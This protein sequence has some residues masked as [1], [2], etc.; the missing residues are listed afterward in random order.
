MNHNEIDSTQKILVNL[1][2]FNKSSIDFMVYTFTITTNW[3][4]YLRVKQDVLL[5]INEIIE[6][7]NA[8]IAFPT[9]TIHSEDSNHEDNDHIVQNMIS[10]N[11]KRL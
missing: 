4:E 1:I 2:R 8:Q 3:A 11:P 10:K 7:N 5:K 6:C 9:T